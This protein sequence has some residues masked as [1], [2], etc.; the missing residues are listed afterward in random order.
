M[1]GAP[2]DALHVDGDGDVG[3]GT[4][5]PVLDVSVATGDT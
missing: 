1:A 5:S 2:A 4:S 3:V